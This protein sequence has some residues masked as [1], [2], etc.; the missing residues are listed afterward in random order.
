MVKNRN[1]S[2]EEYEWKRRER[3]PYDKK[4]KKVTRGLNNDIGRAFGLGRWRGG[5]GKRARR[6]STWMMRG[7][8][9]QKRFPYCPPIARE[10]RAPLLGGPAAADRQRSPE[11]RSLGIRAR[12]NHRCQSDP[13]VRL[14]RFYGWPKNSKRIRTRRHFVRTIDEE[15]FW[16]CFF[17]NSTKRKLFQKKTAT[18][19]Y[20]NM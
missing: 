16:Q 5:G 11:S 1:V 8:G 9:R 10:F 13:A 2:S 18:I 4:I 20:Y 15:T 6:K 7:N 14:L 12:K 19:T 3:L 17:A